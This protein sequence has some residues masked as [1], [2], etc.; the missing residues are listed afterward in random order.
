MQHSARHTSISSSAKSAIIF[1]IVA[2]VLGCA[3]WLGWSLLHRKY[4]LPTFSGL[5]SSVKVSV[6]I[7]GAPESLDIRTTDDD[8]LDRVL[9]GNVY[10]T[11]LKRD[12]NNKIQPSL[13]SSWKVSED[14]T[15]Y[16]FNLRSGATFA[17][18]ATITSSDAV[19]S[20]QQIITK[21]YVGS[22]ELSALSNVESDGNRTL[23]LRLREP[24]PRLLAKLT[25]RIGIVYNQRENIDY[26]KQ[27]SGSG[28]F[29]VSQ[30]QS[31]KQLTL[32][33]NDHY[34]GSKSKAKTV[35]V[36]FAANTTE[37][38]KALNNG[39]IDAAVAL[40]QSAADAVKDDGI[41]KK[42]GVSNRKVVL[43]FSNNTQS[44]LSDKRF[45]QAVRYLIDK[46]AMTEALGGG[47]VMTGPLSPLDDGYQKTDETFGHDIGK[48]N[49][50][51]K[52]FRFRVSRRP[53]T[54]VYP[55]EYGSQI[56]E[57]IKQTMYAEPA[58]SDVSVS[59]VDDATWSKTVTQD[60]QYD[61]TIYET[62]GEDDLD[63]LMDSNSY[64]GFVSTDSQNA[65]SKALKSFSSD[66]YAKN[67]QSFIGTLDDDSPVDWICTRKPI[68]AYRSNITGVPVNMTYTQLPL[69][70]MTTTD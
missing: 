56:G 54:F 15:T 55:K 32:S 51:I 34:W 40:D 2:G 13:A 7:T 33:R 30:W 49:D 47:T 9:L 26:A 35:T 36:N 24:D 17:D 27:A 66:D 50:L 21:K 8:S 38:A 59:M 10:E 42:Q 68:S 3:V 16:R 37:L 4:T 45:R 58:Y 52:Y 14:G 20:L 67:F 48:G 61:F 6:G 22:D 64:I 63:L 5:Q 23:V 44:I 46:N 53:L 12:D 65:W 43:A 62:D 70:D 31:G 11:L 57:Q 60:R 29:T 69:A 18:G 39:Q 19:W 28:P 41:V 25:T 1:V